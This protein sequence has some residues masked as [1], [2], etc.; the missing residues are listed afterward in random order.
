METKNKSIQIKPIDPKRP[1]SST[2]TVKTKY[3]DYMY[4]YSL[5]HL[6]E[7]FTD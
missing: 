2:V 1:I 5:I 4:P 3:F 6:F 7:N